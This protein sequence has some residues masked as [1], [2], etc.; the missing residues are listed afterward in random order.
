M[1]TKKQAITLLE[2]KGLLF[3]G[4]D[5]VDGDVGDVLQV[6]SEYALMTIKEIREGDY[7]TAIQ[8]GDDEFPS[9]LWDENKLDNLIE[10]IES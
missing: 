7:V 9:V 6:M 10:Q 1:P 8:E 4:G 5:I 3:S 2:A